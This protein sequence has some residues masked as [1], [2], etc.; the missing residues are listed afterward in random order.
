M[1]SGLFPTELLWKRRD[2]PDTRPITREGNNTSAKGTG[3]HASS[4]IRT[5]FLSGRAIVADVI[6]SMFYIIKI[7]ERN[8][9][10]IAAVLHDKE[11]A[12]SIMGHSAI[13]IPPAG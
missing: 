3:I 2:H 12:V 9:S 7:L 1:P 6:G 8:M 13:Y 5:Q 10:Y 4:A 11:A